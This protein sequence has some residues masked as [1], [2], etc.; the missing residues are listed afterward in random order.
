MR[1]ASGRVGAYV[2]R[3]PAHTRSDVPPTVSRHPATGTFGFPIYHPA[4]RAAW[5]AWLAANHGHQRGVWLC[6]WREDA[7]GGCGYEDAVEEAAGRMTDAGRRAIETAKANGW[8][9]LMDSVEDLVEPDDLAAALDANAAGRA[10]WDAFPPSARK[11]MLW[12][13]VTAVRPDTRARR[14]AR[15]VD[16]AADGRRTQG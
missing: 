6:T 12:W 14:I 16:D 2:R 15:I 8:W 7:R 5:R 1:T 3:M 9:T 13:L 11:A 4:S 10:A